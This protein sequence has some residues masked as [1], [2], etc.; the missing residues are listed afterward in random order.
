MRSYMS[1]KFPYFAATAA[2][3]IRLIA[4]EKSR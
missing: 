2:R 4:S 3:P 1:N